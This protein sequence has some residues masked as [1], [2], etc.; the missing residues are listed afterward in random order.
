MN[1]LQK[2][3]RSMYHASCDTAEVDGAYYINLGNMLVLFRFSEK[4]ISRED[5]EE[6][7]EVRDEPGTTRP[8][9]TRRKRVHDDDEVLDDA[10]G[11]R[12]PGPR[13]KNEDI[14]GCPTDLVEILEAVEISRTQ[15]MLRRVLG[16]WRL[17]SVDRSVDRSG[18]SITV[19]WT[20]PENRGEVLENRGEHHRSVDRGT[21]SR[22]C[23]GQISSGPPADFERSCCERGDHVVPESCGPKVPA[24]EPE[25]GVVRATTEVAS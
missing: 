7:A 15:K 16:G 23:S 17:R 18:G 24:V 13:E 14:G 25:L 19:P 12:I 4:F 10:D 3:F 11:R 6:D 9:H 8:R 5:V 2:F 21:T 22:T 1:L 20:V